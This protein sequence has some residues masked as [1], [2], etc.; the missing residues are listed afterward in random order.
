MSELQLQISEATKVAMKARDKQRVAALRLINAE[1][2]RVE[3]DERRELK[4]EDVLTI[5]NRML[6]QR[7]DSLA[8]FRAAD[9]ID[10]ADQEQFEMEGLVLLTHIGLATA[11]AECQSQRERALRCRAATVQAV[12]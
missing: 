8:Q 12:L 3:V 10:L 1:F 9:R 5:L 6:K 11:N 4:D 7:N 2:K